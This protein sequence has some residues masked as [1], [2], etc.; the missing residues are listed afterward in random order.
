MFFNSAR[1]T[2]RLVILTNLSKEASR[3]EPTSNEEG[4]RG[5]QGKMKYIPLSK[6]DVLGKLKIFR[7]GMQVSNLTFYKKKEQILRIN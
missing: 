5:V 3:V 6:T 2:D 1:K 4:G 7:K